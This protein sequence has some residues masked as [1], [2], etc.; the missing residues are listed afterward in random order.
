V[1]DKGAG[2]G[3]LRLADTPEHFVGTDLHSFIGHIQDVE[4]SPSEY[5]LGKAQLFF[6]PGWIGIWRL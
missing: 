4:A 6:D 5:L 2:G 1:V 3:S